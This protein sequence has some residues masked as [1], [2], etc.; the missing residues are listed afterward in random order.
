MESYSAAPTRSSGV[1][2]GGVGGSQL[3]V[4]FVK[5]RS[6]QKDNSFSR[7]IKAGGGG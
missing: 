7:D 3:A 5:E 1:C 4:A 6:L 2:V